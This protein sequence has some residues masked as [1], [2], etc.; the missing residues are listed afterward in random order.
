MNRIDFEFSKNLES[1]GDKFNKVILINAYLIAKE[2]RK[3]FFH[4]ILKII[5]EVHK[6][7][8]LFKSWNLSCYYI[9]SKKENSIHLLY[10]VNDDNLFFKDKFIP[11]S[12]LEIESHDNVLLNNVSHKER[13]EIMGYINPTEPINFHNNKYLLKVCFRSNTHNIDVATSTEYFYS[14]TFNDTIWWES[15]VDENLSIIKDKLT[16]LNSIL[17]NHNIYVFMVLSDKKYKNI[18]IFT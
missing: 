5:D 12:S 11:Y 9:Y 8:L 3:G 6:L 1:I 10:I 18:R 16:D 4:G 17:S 2:K 14:V 7:L 13:G 15:L